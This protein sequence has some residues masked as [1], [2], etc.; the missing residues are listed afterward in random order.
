MENDGIMILLIFAV[1]ILL[2]VS[3]VFAVLAVSRR[4][5]EKKKRAYRGIAQGTVVEI[6][7]K[8][9]DHPWVV[10][11]VYKVHG[12]EYQIR[13]TAKLKSETVRIG[14]L[15][16]GQRKTFVLGP[17]REGD[18][19]EVRY[20]MEHPEKGILYGNDGCITG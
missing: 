5:R 17:L 20:D 1:L 12:Q 11:V 16:V 13:E 8:G 2:P 10:Y 6:R 7:N 3:T 18:S 4:N 19:V 15:P 14:R 9:L